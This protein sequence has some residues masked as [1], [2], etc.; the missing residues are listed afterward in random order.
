MRKIQHLIFTASLFF[1]LAVSCRAATI[2]MGNFILIPNTAGQTIQLEAT[3]IAPG[4]VNGMTLSIAIGDGGPGY[5]GI[6][7][8]K[9]TSIDIDSG[10]TIWVP[11]SAPLGHVPPTT[12]IDPDGQI[13]SVT[14]LTVSGSVSAS[15]GRLAT[16]V[17]DTTGI[18]GL[19]KI[20]LSGI[21]LDDVIGSTAFTGYAATTNINYQF[22]DGTGGQLFVG[23]E[24]PEPSSFVLA[25]IGLIGLVVWKRRKR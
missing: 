14:F 3:G 22:Y 8:P 24:A 18:Y 17:I 5:G 9:I 23:P 19:F 11:P 6:L 4:S 21:L 16:L 12:Y 10:P 25:A 2:D 7:G 1:S 15:S 13:A 20:A